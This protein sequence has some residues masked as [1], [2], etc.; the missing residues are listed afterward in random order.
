MSFLLS[1]FQCRFILFTHISPLHSLDLWFL[2]LARG[3]AQF[4]LIYIPQLVLDCHYVRILLLSSLRLLRL[5]L[6][7]Q[8]SVFGF[9]F[10][11]RSLF[12]SVCMI[13]KWTPTTTSTRTATDV[14][15]EP[16]LKRGSGSG[17]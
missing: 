17:F 9:D 4:I 12:F 13:D 11:F 15:K 14:A 8:N 7:N 1:C 5:R 16:F 10:S 6:R 2:Q 3:L